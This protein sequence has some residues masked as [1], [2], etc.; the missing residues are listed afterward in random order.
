MDLG[1]RGRTALVA[2]SGTGIG[3]AVAEGLAAEGANV[4]LCARTGAVVA[5]AAA[6]LARRHSVRTFSL[7][8]DLS[9]PE[10]AA[11]LVSETASAL[12]APLILVTNAGGPPPGVFDDL[13]DA[14]WERAFHLTLMSAVRLT[15]AALPGMK[16]AGWGRI[17]NIA[18]VSVRQP[19]DGLLLSNALRAA[20]VGL[21]KTL[22]REVGPGGILVNNVCPG[23]TL[24]DRL[25]ELV[26][27]R[28]R[29]GGTT[30][31]AVID[32]LEARTPLGR[33]GD[34]AEVAALAVFLCSGA[35][36]YITGQTICVDGG[37][38]AGLP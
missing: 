6:D 4:A 25:R 5:K 9:E 24:T 15:R 14:A 38:V 30:P 27:G 3:R 28:A 11:K 29:E 31:E 1:I 35:A 19:I 18:S 16:K 36:S 10:S 13:D 22:S 2:A 7:Q 21:A 34:P 32:G 37:L 12:G 17:V 26:E 8:C 20:V 33:I 23:Y